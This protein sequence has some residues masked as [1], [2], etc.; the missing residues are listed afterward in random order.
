MSQ[1]IQALAILGVSLFGIDRLVLG[2]G[3]IARKFGVPIFLIGVTIPAILASLPELAVSIKTAAAEN[4]SLG[5]S[6]VVGANIVNLGLI[7]GLII[8]AAPAQ[9]AA[10][11]LEKTAFALLAI[12][13]LF[14]SLMLDSFL[15]RIDGLV[16][17]TGSVIVF[18][19]LIRLETS[20]GPIFTSYDKE[21]GSDISIKSSSL[22]IVV[23]LIVLIA[24]YL[25]FVTSDTFDWSRTNDGSTNQVALGVIVFGLLTSVPELVFGI[26]SALRKEFNFALGMAIGSC[27]ANITLAA[28]MSMAIE[29][30]RV[31]PTVLSLHIFVMVAFVLTFLAMVFDRK[32]VKKRFSKLEGAAL[33]TGYVA[34]AIYVGNAM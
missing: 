33:L 3:G 14:V 34:F 19:W 17:L 1:A 6:T 30:T 29:P 2:C 27:V 20:Q 31:P 25:T 24:A 22:N 5:I 18:V 8:L 12:T 21:F 4:S 11:D 32:G 15:S 13:I 23:G 10:E 7:L 16:L 9:E 26:V 28:G